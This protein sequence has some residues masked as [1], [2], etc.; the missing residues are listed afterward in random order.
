MI[1]SAN[2]QRIKTS[3]ELTDYRDALEQATTEMDNIIS[4]RRQ[5]N[6]SYPSESVLT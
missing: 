5:F 1:V 6:S 2:Y 4:S 3:K